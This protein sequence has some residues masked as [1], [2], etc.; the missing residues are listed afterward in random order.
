[1][2]K[3]DF[4]RYLIRKISLANQQTLCGSQNLFLNQSKRLSKIIK[5][6]RKN[7]ILKIENQKKTRISNPIKAFEEPQK[8]QYKIPTNGRGY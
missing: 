5:T 4:K 3:I 8:V 7:K 2:A 1:M 6:K